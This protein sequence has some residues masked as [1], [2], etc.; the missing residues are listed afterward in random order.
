MMCE[1]KLSMKVSKETW[2]CSTDFVRWLPERRPAAAVTNQKLVNAPEDPKME[3]EQEQQQ[4][5]IFLPPRS[6]CSLPT[7]AAVSMAAMIE[8]KL[9]NVGGNEPFVLTRCKSEPMRTAATKLMPEACF[10]K[11]RKLGWIFLIRFC[12]G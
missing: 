4:P 5:E 8:Q 1:P 3:Q 10:W 11:N 9:V 6:S 2:V 12:F 7:V